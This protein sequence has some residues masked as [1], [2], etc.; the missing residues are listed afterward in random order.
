MFTRP[1]PGQA[2]RIEDRRSTRAVLSAA[3]ELPPQPWTLTVCRAVLGELLAL[4]AVSHPVFDALSLALTEACTNAIRHAAASRHYRVEIDV[5]DD[6]CT[7][8]VADHGPGFDPAHLST[9]PRADYGGWGLP[10]VQSMVDEVHIR[11]RQPGTQLI[12][13]KYLP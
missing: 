8:S 4:A 12:M 9:T 6:R 10:I 13:T 1:D 2:T 5:D 11:P 3:V 7:I